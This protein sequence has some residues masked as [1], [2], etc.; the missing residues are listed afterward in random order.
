MDFGGAES[1]RFFF[2]SGTDSRYELALLPAGGCNGGTAGG[3]ERGGDRGFAGAFVWERV[4]GWSGAFG[5]S[6]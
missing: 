6:R 5:A 1:Y 2:G 4:G 3:F